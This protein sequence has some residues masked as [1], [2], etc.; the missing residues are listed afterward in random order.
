M[1]NLTKHTKVTEAGKT[2]AVNGH[3]VPELSAIQAEEER[4]NA[5][6]ERIESQKQA[7]E[8]RKRQAQE[9]ERN[10]LVAERDSLLE[11]ARDFRQQARQ[12][13]NEDEK[14]TLYSF[15]ADSE[16]QARDIDRKLGLATSDP[17][18]ASPDK[19]WFEQHH[20]LTLAFQ[21]L[22]VFVSLWVAYNSFTDLHNMIQEVNK[23]LAFDKQMQPYDLTSVQKFAYEKFVQLTDLPIAL[24]LLMFVVPMVGFYVLPFVQS[25]K[26]F[27]REFFDE[28]TPWQRSKLAT[29][30]ILGFL[31][32]AALSHLVKP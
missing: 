11:D 27:Y 9:T 31:L 22:G 16:R 4:L 7:I 3:V 8:D 13:P 18:E 29:C 24:L 32:L 6:L 1:Q 5:D 15:A 14:R 12:A 26:D 21:L 25:G 2:L 20:R 23:S 10:Q 17:S 28:L 30:F 19:R